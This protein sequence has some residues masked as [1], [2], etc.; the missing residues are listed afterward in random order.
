MAA[1]K[2]M[3]MKAGVEMAAAVTVRELV[4][5]MAA[6]VR[7]YR[8]SKRVMRFEPGKALAFLACEKRPPTRGIAS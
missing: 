7:F 3:E 2:E 5:W 8:L 4:G 1:A 6:A